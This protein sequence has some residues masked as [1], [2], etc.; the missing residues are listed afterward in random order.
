MNRIVLAGG[1]KKFKE[2]GE[3]GIIYNI[4]KDDWYL[5]EKLTI[6]KNSPALCF[7][8]NKLFIFGGSLVD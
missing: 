1:Y 7:T 4:I 6:H 8:D 5:T 3:H 2:L